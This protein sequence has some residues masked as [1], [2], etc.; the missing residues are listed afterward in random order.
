MGIKPCQEVR[1]ESS[2][3]ILTIKF[4]DEN[5]AGSSIA[6]ITRTYTAADV[7]TARADIARAAL[8]EQ[9]RAAFQAVEEAVA[10]GT[11]TDFSAAWAK[12]AE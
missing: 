3:T 12:G 6:A 9:C 10:A 8:L 2:D 11:V 4:F 1:N 5:H 7:A